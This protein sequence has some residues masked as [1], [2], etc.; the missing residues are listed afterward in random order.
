M[1]YIQ[2]MTNMKIFSVLKIK[3][4][5]L[6]LPI[7]WIANFGFSTIKLFF[8]HELQMT[9][10]FMRISFPLNICGGGL[11]SCSPSNDFFFF[12]FFCFLNGWLYG[13]NRLCPAYELFFFHVSI[14]ENMFLSCIMDN[15]NIL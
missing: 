12:F 15:Q 7:I 14:Y 5:G 2:I 9:L 3:E 6:F 13:R 10:I 8:P 4:Y 1:H 11:N